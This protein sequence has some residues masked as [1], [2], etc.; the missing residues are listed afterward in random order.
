L[1]IY[2]LFFLL[3]KNINKTFLTVR[4]WGTYFQNVS[5]LCSKNFME[6]ISN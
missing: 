1:W 4:K 5:N 3:A 6:N 2:T